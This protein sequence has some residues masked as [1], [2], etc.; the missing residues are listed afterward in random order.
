MF[1]GVP[2]KFEP[3]REERADRALSRGSWRLVA[4]V[5]TLSAVTMLGKLFFADAFTGSNPP[6]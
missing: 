1:D 2:P 5:L 6:L 4:L 3:D